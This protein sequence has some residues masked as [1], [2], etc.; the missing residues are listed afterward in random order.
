MFVCRALAQIAQPTLTIETWP[1]VALNIE[2]TWSDQDKRM[3]IQNEAQLN[4]EFWERRV[5]VIFEFCKGASPI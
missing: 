5:V 1:P 2:Q 4:G 3:I